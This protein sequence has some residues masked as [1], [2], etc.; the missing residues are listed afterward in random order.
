MDFSFLGS[1]SFIMHNSVKLEI[2]IQSIDV[3]PHLHTDPTF[4]YHY[5]SSNPNQQRNG[6]ALVQLTKE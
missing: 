5:V 6:G 1:L 4:V 2:A 3:Q